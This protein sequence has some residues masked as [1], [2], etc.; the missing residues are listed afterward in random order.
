MSGEFAPKPE[1]DKSPLGCLWV[2]SLA[3]LFGLICA[4]GGYLVAVRFVHVDQKARDAPAA[5]AKPV[6][7]AQVPAAAK[8]MG[9]TEPGGA[10]S[11]NRLRQIMLAM[12]SHHSQFRTF[13]PP[14]NAS[15]DADG[16]PLLS[17]RVHLLPF[18][19]Q[20]SLYELFHL[21]EP[22]DS[23]HNR[24]LLD[25]MPDVY[26]SRGI[27]AD[28]NRT[29]FVL[30]QHPEMYPIDKQGPKLPAF[31]DGTSN[32]LMV[33]EVGPEL[34]VPWTRPDDL[35]FDPKEPLAALGKLPQ[36][37]LWGGFADGAVRRIR[38]DIRPDVF[39]GI[40][41]SSGQEVLQLERQVEAR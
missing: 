26:R 29:G 19:E 4:L 15:Y 1:V 25:K 41:T 17:W 24:A 34:A 23:E 37:G 40:L 39:R 2:A 33:L 10:K 36:D 6:V 28:G 7:Q 8:E 3:I 14:S 13:P 18:V 22:W 16:R 38:A 35:S 5:D 9:A 12:H 31:R 32:T 20:N 27:A 21:D 30:F 11:K